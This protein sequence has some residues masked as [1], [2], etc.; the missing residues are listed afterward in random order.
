MSIEQLRTVRT[1]SAKDSADEDGFYSIFIRD[2]V[3]SCMIGAYDHERL[4]SQRVR[5]NVDMRVRSEKR[6]LND[7]LDNVLSYDAIVAG[8]KRL[9]ADRHINLVET[10]AAEIAEACLADWRV[11]RVRVRVEKLDVEP[12]AAAVGV[13]IE[14]RRNEAP[15]VAEVF[16]FAFGSSKA[17]GRGDD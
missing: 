4:N 17:P 8:I 16:P 12:Q 9:I 7:D 13:E 14:R 3:L 11:L 6:P 15:S 5:F 10:L 2:L 1:P